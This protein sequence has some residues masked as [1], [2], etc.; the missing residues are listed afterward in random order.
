MIDHLQGIHHIDK[1]GL[2]ETQDAVTQRINKVFGKD[3]D[4]SNVI[5][6]SLNNFFFDG[7]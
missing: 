6:T 1:D 7:S 2:M 4:K 3:T 5:L